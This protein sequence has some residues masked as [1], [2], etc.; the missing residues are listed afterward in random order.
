MDFY[1]P[2]AIVRPAD[3]LETMLAR[4]GANKKPRISDASVIQEVL[5]QLEA[6]F[7]RIEEFTYKRY[8]REITYKIMFNLGDGSPRAG[9]ESAFDEEQQPR[10][11]K[12]V[13][14]KVVLLR[15]DA[16]ALVIV[17]KRSFKDNFDWWNYKGVSYV[18]VDKTGVFKSNFMDAHNY[19]QNYHQKLQKSKQKEAK[20]KG[21]GNMD[22]SAK[23]AR[24]PL[25]YTRRY[26]KRKM[27]N[28][29]K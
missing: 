9:F 18:F 21:N 29:M 16:P 7:Y 23:S 27:P 19:Y 13:L 25:H 15:K 1:T 22:L 2:P 24:I 6:P 28:K 14:D 10:L 12:V 3:S 5:R 17:Y 20:Q 4:Y 8:G 11:D 26:L